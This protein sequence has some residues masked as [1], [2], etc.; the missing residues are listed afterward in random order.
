MSTTK[1]LMLAPKEASCLHNG[2]MEHFLSVNAM[3][4]NAK[5]KDITF[6]DLRNGLGSISHKLLHV[7][8]P[9]EISSYINDMSSKLT[10]YFDTKLWTTECVEFFR[11]TLC[12]PFYSFLHSIQLSSSSNYC[13][14]EGFV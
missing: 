12:H 6:I 3:L 9:T 11:M 2:I 8:I 1:L 14:A 5:D 4:Q 13:H 7:K 10:T